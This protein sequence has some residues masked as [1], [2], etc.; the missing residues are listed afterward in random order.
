MAED[1]DG[2]A[3]VAELNG[4]KIFRVPLSREHAAIPRWIELIAGLF[5]N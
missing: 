5:R 3:Y 1:D 2:N 4:Y